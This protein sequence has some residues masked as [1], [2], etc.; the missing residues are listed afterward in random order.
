MSDALSAHFID[1]FELDDLK[2]FLV[3][4][5]WKPSKTRNNDWIVFVGLP[6]INGEPLEIVLPSNEGRPNTRLFIASA[7]NTL[8]DISEVLP[9]ELVLKIKYHDRDV[10]KIWNPETNGTDSIPLGVA[11]QQVA[12]LKQLVAYSAC[13]E[14]NPKPFFSNTQNSLAKR[15][16]TRY[17][18][19]HTFRGS[20]GFTVETPAISKLQF[21]TQ[22]SMIPDTVN[23]KAYSPVERKVMERIV[24][25][26]I[27]TQEATSTKN[28]QLIIDNYEQGFNSNMCRAI[29]N[30]SM[31]KDR[32]LE[33]SISW[34]ARVIPHDETIREPGIIRLNSNSYENLEYAAKILSEI[35]PEEVTVRG[36]ITELS[37]NDN[38]LGLDTSRLILIRWYDEIERLSHKVYVVLSKEDYLM[39]ITAHKEWV[40]VSI[41]GTLKR[42]KNVWRLVDYHD[43]SIG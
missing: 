10:F 14:E 25:G 12:E 8:C 21:A 29:V 24:R 31:G 9:D 39:A 41:K 17:Q 42:V 26:L 37:T 11:A 4:T 27:I 3:D 19:G 5:G 16:V 2:G 35:E 36:L 6:D 18:F 23:D 28:V 33:C 32:P 20:F 15:M 34:S 30:M 13:S 43:L 22:Q 1:R 40:P 38:P 7:F